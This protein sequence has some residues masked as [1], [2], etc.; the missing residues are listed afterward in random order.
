MDLT[1]K[2][3]I[4]GGDDEIV[5]GDRDDTNIG[6]RRACSDNADCSGGND[7]IKSG[8]GDDKDVVTMQTV[9]LTA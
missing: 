6:D 1:E 5:S 8:K 4:T 3:R 7:K 2:R 9:R